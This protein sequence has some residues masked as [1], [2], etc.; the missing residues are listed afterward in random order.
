MLFV[1][2]VCIWAFVML[3]SEANCSCLLG[4][5]SITEVYIHPTTVDTFDK[6]SVLKAWGPVLV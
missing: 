3:P 2:I 4:K 6:K 5:H 1:Y